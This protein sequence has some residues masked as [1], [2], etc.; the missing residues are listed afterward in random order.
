MLFLIQLLVLNV[1]LEQPEPPEPKTDWAAIFRQATQQGTVTSFDPP[2]SLWDNGVA[3][4]TIGITSQ[5]S[6]GL[7]TARTADDF[8]FNAPCLSGYYRI[9]R[10]RVQVSQQ[11]S[12]SQ[13]FA[14][15]IYESDGMGYPSSTSAT[16]P[17]TSRTLIGDLNG[18][19]LYEVE[20]L[21]PEFELFQ[22]T[23]YWLSPYGTDAPA[24]DT[25]VNYF[26][27]SDSPGD[28]VFIAPD[29]GFPQWV[30]IGT[31]GS[32]G[33]QELAFA[34]DG[35][36]LPVPPRTK[37]LEGPEFQVNTETLGYQ[38]YPS[39][40]RSV[41]GGFIIV[42][43][44]EETVRAQR[45]AADGSRLGDELFVSDA[46]GHTETV[47]IGVDAA[48]DF[49]VVWGPGPV[50]G[51]GFGIGARRFASD[52]NAI[53]DAFLV[54]TY[55]TGGQG[56]PTIAVEPTG[57][58]IVVWDSWGTFGDDTSETSIQGQR[59]FDDGSL[60]GGQFQINSYTTN[61]QSDPSAAIGEDGSFAITWY[62]V[63]SGGSE[64]L[65]T[66]QLRRFDS[67][68]LP[69]GTDYQVSTFTTSIQDNP[70]LSIGEGG[71]FVI[72][73]Q[74]FGQHPQYPYHRSVIGRSFDATG[75]PLS[76]D[77]PVEIFPASSQRNPSV[78]HA[79]NGT[80]VITWQTDLTQNGDPTSYSIQARRFKP[81]GV[82]LE[83]AFLVNTFTSNAQQYPAIA[84]GLDGGFVVVW[85]SRGSDGGD[86]DRTSIQGQRFRELLFSDGFESGD[87][88]AW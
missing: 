19:D 71:A 30:D 60:K 5:N 41:D 80:F 48:G 46:I 10:V 8:W 47:D 45:H 54:N 56:R 18:D 58:F 24:N 86:E 7:Y 76:D 74:S 79:E 35:A 15:E 39:I 64:A 63:L 84:G 13:P 87:V 32:F 12:Y 73:W 16:F 51:D 72:A 11:T 52:G 3:N 27:A 6:L 38:E 65:A 68:A 40:A 21:T 37:L 4:N 2:G 49:T 66:I 53:G 78:G 34:I 77:F 83:E 85:Q 61:G 23:T 82:P 70:D 75:A 14:L 31:L 42:W 81:N 50:P 17:E 36:C 55:T 59:F 62:S 29:S 88:A 57:D 69:L 44:S 28:G 20:F 43:V 1:L 25:F 33:S 26:A 9:A 22:F 67:N